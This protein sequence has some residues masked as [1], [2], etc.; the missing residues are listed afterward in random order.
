MTWNRLPPETRCGGDFLVGGIESEINTGSKL[1][2]RS[3]STLL[4]YERD[5]YLGPMSP[6]NNTERVE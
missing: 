4:V 2:H 5:H 1:A 6:L 3:I